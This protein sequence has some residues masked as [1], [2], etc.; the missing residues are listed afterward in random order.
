EA[1]LMADARD[2]WRYAVDE[3][4]Y[5]PEDI[6]LFG[7]SLG[8]GVATGLAYDLCQQ[9][10]AP[11]GL[12][13]RATFS[14]LVAAAGYHYPF[15]PVSWV[16]VDRFPSLER[17]PAIT[18]PILVLHGDR[19]SIIP[20]EQGDALYAA[21]PEKSANGIPKQFVRLTG[22]GH[23]D[24]LYVAAEPV[25]TA[26]ERFFGRLPLPSAGHQ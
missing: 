13:L 17:I 21:A 18:C 9:G 7:E 19:D 24:I 11:A 12:I 4:K 2:V 3:L 15:L 8:G 16:L 22:A 1:A 25:R 6:V 26:L 10:T 14:S 5:A 23:N 20:I